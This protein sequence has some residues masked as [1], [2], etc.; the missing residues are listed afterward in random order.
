[1][2]VAGKQA[3]VRETWRL[4]CRGEGGWEVLE[5]SAKEGARVEEVLE[6]AEWVESEKLPR[7]FMLPS[8]GEPTACTDRYCSESSPMPITASVSG[9]AKP[10]PISLPLLAPFA[11]LE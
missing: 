5:V 6:C 2:A 11:A 7:R 1:V 3:D 8:E 10:K 4:C 9:G